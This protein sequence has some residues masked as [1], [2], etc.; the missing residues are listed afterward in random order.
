M[1]DFDLWKKVR[2]KMSIQDRAEILGGPPSGWEEY[3]GGD[4][5]GTDKGRVVI[6]HETQRPVDEDTA[7]A[8]LDPERPYGPPLRIRYSLED[9]GWQEAAAKQDKEIRQLLDN[10][11]VDLARFAVFGLSHVPLLIHLGFLLTDRVDVRLFQYHRDAG[12]WDWADAPEGERKLVRISGF[13]ESRVEGETDVTVRVSLSARISPADTRKWVGAE[14]PEIDLEV[15]E[16]DV[17]W[18]QEPG[19]LTELRKAFREVL[20]NI[21]NGFPDC[22]RIHLFYAGPAPGAVAL[23]QSI[24]P[25]MNP[26]VV[27]YDYDYN[28]TP[29]YEEALTL[30]GL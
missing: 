1:R 11:G 27:T 19:Q 14:S 3:F 22:S 2:D 29:R 26:P 6:L 5:S 21:R 12:S 20:K 15:A 16:P 23:G 10:V 18:L 8:A 7:I 13:P 17:L 9:L 24:N 28:R 30:S 4:E 25:T